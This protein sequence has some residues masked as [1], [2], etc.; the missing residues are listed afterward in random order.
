M[1]NPLPGTQITHPLLKFLIGFM[2]ALCAALF[3][4][5]MTALSSATE[6][7]QYVWFGGAYLTLSL[8]F[9]TIVGLIV[10]ILEYGIPKEPRLTFLTALGIP[11]LL[12]GALNTNFSAKDAQKAED[13]KGELEA[14]VQEFAQIPVLEPASITALDQDPPVAKTPSGSFI[15]LSGPSAAYASNGEPVSAQAA[16]FDPTIQRKEPRYVVVL[17]KTFTA[18]EARDAAGALERLVPKLEVVRSGQF[19]LVILGGGPK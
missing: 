15:P 16:G 7:D 18:Q 11:A 14:M 5:L 10:V 1:P 9:A 19:Y 12:A 2:A 3:P 8:V 17:R 4:R 6:I 13:K